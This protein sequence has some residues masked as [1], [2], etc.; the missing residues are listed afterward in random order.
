MGR[1]E[2]TRELARKRSRK[3]KLKK[4]R[5]KLATTKDAGTKVALVEKAKK[6]SPFCE[7]GEES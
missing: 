1:V 4:L 2:R 7:L 6:I 5:K 3:A